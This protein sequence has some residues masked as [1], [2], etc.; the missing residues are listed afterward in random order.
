MLP[1]QFFIKMIL[2]KIAKKWIDISAK[3][4]ELGTAPV[5]DLI[6]EMGG[7]PILGDAF[8]SNGFVLEDVLGKFR[9][10]YG[11][12]SVI[13]SYVGA[14]SKSSLDYILHVSYVDK[15]IIIVQSMI[16]THFILSTFPSFKWRLFC[17]EQLQ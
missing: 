1:I 2:Q 4:D 12:Y 6:K 16:T 3:I 10:V 9:A 11:T 5:L 15:W 14:D 17:S 8:D 13:T 7:W